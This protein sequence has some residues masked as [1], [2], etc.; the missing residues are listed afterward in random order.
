M[1]EGRTSYAFRIFDHSRNR[2]M[3][4]KI[5]KKSFN[6]KVDDIEAANNRLTT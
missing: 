6:G 2:K 4:G 5:D 3:V 1:G